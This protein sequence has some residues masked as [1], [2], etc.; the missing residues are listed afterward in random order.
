ML[1]SFTGLAGIALF[2][3]IKYATKIIGPDG[4]FGVKILPP[5]PFL[6]TMIILFISGIIIHVMV[7]LNIKGR[8]YFI[9]SILP[10]ILNVTNIFYQLKTINE[11]GIYWIGKAI[12]EGQP[13][14]EN[15]F[16]KL[17]AFAI[18]AVCVAGI[19]ISVSF[20]FRQKKEGND[21]E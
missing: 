15:S 7:L 2:F 13:F 21:Y 9:I 10:G 20:S 1:S 12:F 6:I 4:F 18:I 11:N 16:F 8:N 3:S 17:F 5:E 19:T 14:S